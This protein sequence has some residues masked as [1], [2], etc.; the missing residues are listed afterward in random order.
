MF[1]SDSAEN[2]LQGFH[3]RHTDSLIHCRVDQ[4]HRLDHDLNEKKSVCTGSSGCLSLSREGSSC[5]GHTKL[6]TQPHLSP[7]C[8]TRL[9]TVPRQGPQSSRTGNRPPPTLTTPQP[10]HTSSDGEKVAYRSSCFSAF[11]WGGGALILLLGVSLQKH[12]TAP[13]HQL[14]STVNPKEKIRHRDYL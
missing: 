6:N 13:L 8:P 2:S 5:S 9:P 14:C 1:S 11:P 10:R 7:D 4:L 3:V 12:I